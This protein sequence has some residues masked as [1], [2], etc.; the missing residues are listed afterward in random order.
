V[1][2]YPG[3]TFPQIK[4]LVSRFVRAKREVGEDL[5]AQMREVA[6]CG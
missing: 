5:L 4:N 1:I 2:E 3:K 6:S